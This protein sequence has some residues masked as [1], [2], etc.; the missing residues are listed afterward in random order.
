MS[1]EGML[2]TPEAQ[3]FNSFNTPP[4]HVEKLL[5]GVTKFQEIAAIIQKFRSAA[6]PKHTEDSLTGVLE[7]E[8]YSYVDLTVPQKHAEDCWFGVTRAQ[9]Q[10]SSSSKTCPKCVQDMLHTASRPQSQPPNSLTVPPQ[11]VKEPLDAATGSQSQPSIAIT[12]PLQHIKESLNADPASPVSLP[13]AP[14]PQSHTYM[15]LTVPQKH[16]EHCQFG[17]TGAQPQTSSSS[18]THPKR[19]Q[20]T[21]HTAS[22][23]QSLHS[24]SITSPPQHAEE[25]INPASGSQV[26]DT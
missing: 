22:R 8:A 6:S 10:T 7:P 1:L 16:A 4:N 24:T 19:V 17:V 13:G 18:K 15:D 2:D 25:H 9:P 21:L 20:D 23:P 12:A 14:G 26:I 11:C 5:N 3:A